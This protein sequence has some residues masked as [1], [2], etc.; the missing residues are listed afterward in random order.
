MMGTG[1]CHDQWMTV[2][3]NDASSLRFLKLS[4][5]KERPFTHSNN[6]VV[7]DTATILCVRGR[8]IRELGGVKLREWRRM[9]I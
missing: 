3:M 2:Y 4:N 1:I 5:K 7:S 6:R 8:H 9:I